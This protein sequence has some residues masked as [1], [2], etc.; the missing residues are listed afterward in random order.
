MLL[1]IFR[2]WRHFGKQQSL[3][4]MTVT[5]RNVSVISPGKAYFDCCYWVVILT[6]CANRQGDAPRMLL[7]SWQN[8]NW[9]LCF[10][11]HAT[12]FVGRVCV[13]V[14]EATLHMKKLNPCW[15][16]VLRM[17]QSIFFAF[18][19]RFILCW[20]CQVIQLQI[21]AEEQDYQHKEAM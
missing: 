19:W 9:A 8:S 13:S 12:Y 10:I 2:R 21:C 16:F 5:P 18:T 17:L 7:E 6:N 11:G 14:L 3:I 4:N 1:I 20:D 15:I